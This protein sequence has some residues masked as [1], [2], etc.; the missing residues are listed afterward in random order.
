[1]EVKRSCDNVS[2]SSPEQRYTHQLLMQMKQ[3]VDNMSAQLT[4][5]KSSQSSTTERDVDD[6]QQFVSALTSRS[7]GVDPGGYG[8]GP[9]ENM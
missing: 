3:S 2:G 1:M 5:I 4:S 9:P 7:R 6:K 8:S